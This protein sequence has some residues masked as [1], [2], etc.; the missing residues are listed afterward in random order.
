MFK[1]FYNLASSVLTH[2]RHLDVVSNNI[3]NISTPGY[4]QDIYTATTFDEV[5]YSRMGNLDGNTG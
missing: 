2:Q 1:G 3:V 4:K 5:M